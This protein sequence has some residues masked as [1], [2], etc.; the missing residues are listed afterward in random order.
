MVRNLMSR[1]KR[2][3]VHPHDSMSAMDDMQRWVEADFLLS[4]RAAP[5]VQ[6]GGWFFGRL[7][8]ATVQH[9]VR[10]RCGMRRVANHRYLDLTGNLCISLSHCVSKLLANLPSLSI[11]RAQF[12]FDADYVF[13]D[14]QIHWPVFDDNASNS[15]AIDD[16]GR[17]TLERSD[18]FPKHSQHL[19]TLPDRYPVS[20]G[21]A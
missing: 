14:R 17:R 4:L 8:D 7:R 20:I 3:Y 5:R 1:G 13:A 9:V 18:V 12:L 16:G 11:E 2:G 21:K 19:F 6:H 15:I 10:A